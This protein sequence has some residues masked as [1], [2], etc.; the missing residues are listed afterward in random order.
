MATLTRNLVEPK[1]SRRP[2]AA[3]GTVVVCVLFV[4][5]FA[6]DAALQPS[7]LSKTQLALTVQ[8]ALPLILLGAAQTIVMLTGGIDVSIGGIMV[9]AD[10]L[11]S[12]WL[13]GSSG[14]SE[15]HII[16]I[17]GVG[18]VLGSCNGLLVVVAKIEPFIVT[19]ATWSIFDGIALLLLPVPGGETPTGITTWAESTNGFL[20]TPILILVV[21]LAIWWYA[22]D[23]KLFKHIYSVGSDADRARLSG[24]R[25]DRIRFL[26]YVIAGGLAAIAGIY[27]ALSTGTGDPTIGDG[28]ILP[29]VEAAVIGGVALSGGYGGIGLAVMGAFILSFI[30]AIAGELL[31]AP[32]VSIA[33]SAGLLLFV[34]AFRA[35]FE[36]RDGDGEVLAQLTRLLRLPKALISRGQAM[37]THKPAHE[38]PPRPV[39]PAALPESSATPSEQISPWHRLTRRVLSV[40]RVTVGAYGLTLL[41]FIIASVHSSNFAGWANIRQLLVFASFLG[42]AALGE[43]LIILA[44]GMDLSVPWL[45]AFGGIELGKLA[46]SGHG[47]VLSIV[48]VVLIGFGIG[49]LNG[50]LVTGFRVSPLIATLGVGGLVE[51]YLVAIG[52]STGQSVPQ[53]AI[54]LASGGIGPIPVLPLIWLAAAAVTSV[55]L[56]RTTLGRRIYAVGANP[57]AARL[58][59]IHVGRVRFATYVIGGG[60][61]AFAGVLLSGFIQ[62]AYLGDG[63]PYLFGAIAAVALGGAELLGGRGSYW[64]AVAGCLTLTVLNGLLP[65]FGLSAGSLNIGYGIVILVGIYLARNVHRMG[66]RRVKEAT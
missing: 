24:V 62:T 26:A 10:C 64:G 44:G 59:G 65:V 39:E 13:G 54:T 31:L 27:T 50:I 17:V 14:G 34:V 46:G 61:G 16:L 36:R 37:A 43:A 18:V 28:Y 29:S 30:D 3:A 55:V 57:R 20:P 49:A 33:M 21:F 32:W 58:S 40:D 25:V 45:M 2:R 41:L 48:I 9:I 22:R 52:Q 6:V 23:T 38:R 19:L 60:C 7:L 47:A 35:R 42:F 5:L 11:T 8:A 56:R 4:V 53:A 15:W 1:I 12:T 63:A 51:A 66:R